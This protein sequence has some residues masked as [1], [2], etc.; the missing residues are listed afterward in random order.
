LDE[1]SCPRNFKSEG[2]FILAVVFVSAPRSFPFRQMC[3]L[4]RS[5]CLQARTAS[6]LSESHITGQVGVVILPSS[7][8]CS[9]SSG[10]LRSQFWRVL[11]YCISFSSISE[12]RSYREL[13]DKICPFCK[14]EQTAAARNVFQPCILP[15]S[16]ILETAGLR[17]PIEGC[18]GPNFRRSSKSSARPYSCKYVG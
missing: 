16:I 7:A 1:E 2:G 5:S 3:E 17:L 15:N 14:E 6:F 18:V 8:S 9:A 12:S 10:A 11:D 13:C 4:H